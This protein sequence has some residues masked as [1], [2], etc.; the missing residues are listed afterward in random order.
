MREN[1]R[2]MTLVTARLDGRDLGGAVR[3]VQAML[4]STPLPVG[5]SSEV[6]GQYASQR[7][8]F[9]ELLHRRRRRGGA[10]VRDPRRPLPHRSRRRR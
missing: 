6:G 5:Y 2:Q 1:L 3:E 8:A 7:Q 9:Q 10:G 4:A